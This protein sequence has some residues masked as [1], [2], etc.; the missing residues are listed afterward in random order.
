[1]LLACSILTSAVYSSFFTTYRGSIRIQLLFQMDLGLQIIWLLINFMLNLISTG[2]T[3]YIIRKLRKPSRQLIILINLRINLQI[4]QSYISLLRPSI[5][6]LKI[7]IELKLRILIDLAIKSLII[8]IIGVGTG[9]PIYS[10]MRG[11]IGRTY[12]QSLYWNNYY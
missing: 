11:P 6:V 7:L 8:N 3:I 4:T 10:L 2:L 9:V 5:Y 12:N 1:M